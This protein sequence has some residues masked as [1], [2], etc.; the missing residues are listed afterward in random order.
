[1]RLVAP[2]SLSIFTAM[3]LAVSIAPN[4][5]GAT[6]KAGAA[7]SKKGLTQVSSGKKYTCVL[8]GKKLV[9]NQGVPVQTT[10]APSPKPTVSASANADVPKFEPW[11]VKF[12]F[13]VMVE[14]ALQ[15]TSQYFG[16]VTSSD[17]Y[18]ITV[19]PAF[20]N[21]DKDRVNKVLSY[22]N[23]MFSNLN[24]DER[25]VFL[26]TNHQWG[27]S[28]LKANNLWLGDPR[29]PLPCSDG[30]RDAMCAEGKLILLIYSDIYGGMGNYGWDYGRIS[31]PAH[32]FFHTVQASLSSENGIGNQNIQ[33]T[34]LTLPVWLDEGSANFVGFFT[35]NQMQIVDY[36]NARR[37][38]VN[39]NPNYK[40]VYPLSDYI[41]RGNAADG[42]YLDPYGIGQVATEYLVASV[43]FKALI[44]IYKNYKESK[45]FPSAFQQ[46]VGISIEDFYSK[47]EAAR[48]SMRITK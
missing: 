11:S 28:T 44:D 8:K 15:K 5:L 1:M 27:A 16:K 6:A 26:G 47:F 48:S 39:N 30:S 37:M 10:N 21:E 34:K 4:S 33:Q 45:N 14:T 18:Q 35:T 20:K 41:G 19:D 42:T 9:W 22:I 46:A 7:C 2:K 31:V 36:F 13:N 43:G 25:K 17:K 3:V 12:D 40:V 23:G 38:Q 32:E 29:S 24:L